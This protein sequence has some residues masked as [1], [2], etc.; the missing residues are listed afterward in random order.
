[1][2]LACVEEGC[3]R[4]A[5]ARGKCK[6]HYE[7]WLVTALPSEKIRRNVYP[8][9]DEI[10]Q[11]FEEERSLTRVARRLGFNRGTLRDYIDHRPSLSQR[12][13]PLRYLPAEVVLQRQRD[14]ERRWR[15]NNRDKRRAT[16]RRWAAN[17]SAEDV[18]RWNA[19][20][21]DRRKR[22]RHGVV[23]VAEALVQSAYEAILQKDPCAFCGGPAGTVDHIQPINA[24]GPDVWENFTAACLSC[25]ASKKDKTLLHFLLWRLDHVGV[26]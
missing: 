3:A 6:R 13:A 8:S 22:Q 4:P 7:A 11:I 21:R 1:M 24:G 9:D 16:N 19:H 12:V 23:S 15:R 26:S 17:R 25:N 2:T 10:V 14:A 20:N 18:A 5:K